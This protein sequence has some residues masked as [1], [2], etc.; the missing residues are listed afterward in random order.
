MK[1]K[2]KTKKKRKKKKENGMKI[3]KMIQPKLK[4]WLK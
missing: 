2:K 4:E 3:V 1:E